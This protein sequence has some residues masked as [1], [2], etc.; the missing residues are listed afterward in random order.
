[1]A[2]ARVDPTYL[3]QDEQARYRRARRAPAEAYGRAFGWLLVSCLP[4]GGLIWVAVTS[5]DG[6][7][8]QW[9][10]LV[11][12]AVWIVGAYCAIASI[13]AGVKVADDHEEQAVRA[14]LIDVH[15]YDRA[16]LRRRPGDPPVAA[17][18]SDDGGSKTTRQLQHEWYEGHSE[19]N[20]R[21]REMASIWGLDVET[22]ISNVKE[23]DRG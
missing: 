2:K 1:M 6:G 7:F 17:A 21:D 8:E 3:T 22:Y 18:R 11:W 16:R 12:I 10:S 4:V 15:Y 19:L 9:A 13:A 14:F 20:W 23:N 5:A